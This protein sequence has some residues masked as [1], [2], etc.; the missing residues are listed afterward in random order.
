MSS[1]APEHAASKTAT[2]KPSV[3]AVMGPFSRRAGSKSATAIEA[4]FN[5]ANAF[6]AVH[7]V[8]MDE[9]ALTART[10]YRSVHVHP[11]TI[12][13]P[14]F[15]P[16]RVVGLLLM[17]KATR[18]ILSLARSETPSLIVQTFG[19]PL[20][21]GLPVV[22]AAR[23]VGLPSVLSLHSDYGRA[24]R[25]TYSLGLRWLAERCWRYLFR[26][27]TR[28][29]SVSGDGVGFAT[30]RGAAPSAVS[31]IP[32]KEELSTFRAPPSESELQNAARRFGYAALPEG[33]VSLLTVGRL[34][35]AKNIDGMMLGFKE[36]MRD[37][38]NLYYFVVGDG[39]RLEPLRA[40]A[41]EL[42]IESRVRFL[43][44]V[45]HAEL[46]SVYRLSDMLAFVTHYEGQPRVVVEAMLA[47]LPV[48]CSNF[49]QVTEIVRPEI[50][51]L[52]ADPS[53]PGSIGDAMARLAGDAQLRVRASRHEGFD[54]EQF[55][56]ERIGEREAAL[57]LSAIRGDGTVL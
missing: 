53:D 12:R 25:W 26:R 13:T 40:F 54:A 24:M 52:W 1:P 55:S 56:I 14:A 49:G 37:H 16:R 41:Q 23:R 11:L 7:I 27:A 50:D 46:R 29:R 20:K 21:F 3:I 45:D 44:F 9:L 34:I 10:H 31:V 18:V 47:G 39:P 19:T 43:G 30:V 28:I 8:S 17:A 22:L 33:A 36:A 2:A 51:G 38:S 42:G 5:P 6:E 48:I 57:Y 35:A 4:F 15:V 32:N